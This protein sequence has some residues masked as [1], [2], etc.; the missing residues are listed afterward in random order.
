LQVSFAKIKY[1]YFGYLG[2]IFVVFTAW[3]N[4]PRIQVTVSDD[5]C[6]GVT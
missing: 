4:I 1:P 5:Q 3:V 6:C 2:F